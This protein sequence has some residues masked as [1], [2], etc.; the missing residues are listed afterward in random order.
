MNALAV[1]EALWAAA[2]ELAA[3][4][5][6]HPRWFTDAIIDRSR[7]YT[8]ERHA[9]HRSAEAA[10]DLAARALFFS[11]VDA[12]K[13]EAPLVEL[14]ARG[15][16]WPSGPR[17]VVDLGA[18]CG[19]MSLG[20]LATA[21]ARGWGGSWE[22][23]LVDKDLAALRLAER[24]LTHL[25]QTLRL[26]VTV[27]LEVAELTSARPQAALRQA[28]LVLAG[29]LL[30]ELSAAAARS[31]ALAAVPP[32]GALL[33]IEPALRSSARALHLLRDEVLS[34]ASARVLAPCTHALTPCPML[35]RETDW[36]HEDRP[37]PVTP[38]VRAWSEATGLR[39]GNLKYSYLTLAS[40]ESR[41][42]ARPQAP[43]GRLALRVVSGALPGKGR[44]EMSSCGALG[45]APLRRLDRRRGPAT[46]W[47][48]ELRRGDVV[49]APEE[50]VRHG[51]AAGR[52]EILADDTWAALPV[53]PA[54]APPSDDSPTSAADG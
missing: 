12:A 40:G 37:W 28:T 1:E 29:S 11:V 5:R 7:R 13:P 44:K 4:A 36:C 24:A 23:L 39:D 49:L 22:L 25:A 17:R 3:R 15:A 54:A 53:L 43:E 9:L 47:F 27:R 46:E 19:A 33:L 34:S 10:A 30:N 18:G 41:F 26:A 32:G 20:L 6:A 31:L 50:R 8:S 42:G 38:Q 45:R 48:D 52:I 16:D 2:P 21:A 51:V 35:A 14:A